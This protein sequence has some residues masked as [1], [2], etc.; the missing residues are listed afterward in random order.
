MT[1]R[2]RAYSDSFFQSWEAFADVLKETYDRPAADA[3]DIT[4]VRQLR[5]SIV[6]GAL[7]QLLEDLKE[8]EIASEFHALSHAFMDVS[9][10][11]V[12]PIF[13]SQKKKKKRGRANDTTEQWALRAS[14]VI[15]LQFLIAGE[16]GE[17]TAVK[18]AL[19]HKKGLASLLRPGTDLKS[20]VR[21]WLESFE[22]EKVTNE[23]AVETYK[24][25]MER[26]E[27]LKHGFQED[28]L[29]SLGEGLIKKAAERAA[30]R[31]PKKV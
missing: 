20:S 4:L 1:D 24:E 10:G 7:G 21:T 31:L 25:G 9:E 22:A 27:T 26:L 13:V 29:R 23:L 28:V 5:Y 17:E 14:V 19:K 8:R 3:S 11:I 30:S 12:D 16:L 2:I 6:I 15:G 18:T